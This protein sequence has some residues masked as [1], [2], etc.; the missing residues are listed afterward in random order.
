MVSGK[1]TLRL[2]IYFIMKHNVSMLYL[3]EI[4]SLPILLEFESINWK[5][6]TSCPLRGGRVLFSFPFQF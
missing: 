6:P 1:K 3:K 5:F 4:I 2:F